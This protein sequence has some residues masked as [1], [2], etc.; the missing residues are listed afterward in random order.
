M[1]EIVESKTGKI[2]THLKTDNLYIIVSWC[3]IESDWSVGVIYK[4]LDSTELIVRS[5]EEFFDGRFKENTED[6]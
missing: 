4:R 6:A 1:I 5:A 2:F 3:R